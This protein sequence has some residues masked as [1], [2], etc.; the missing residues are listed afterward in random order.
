MGEE[1]GKETCPQEGMT[2]N[3]LQSA[4]RPIKGPPTLGSV[5]EATFLV[6]SSSYSLSYAV[7]VEERPG[8]K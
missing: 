2:K 6:Q 7:D 3:R 5:K 8:C 1:R 4:F